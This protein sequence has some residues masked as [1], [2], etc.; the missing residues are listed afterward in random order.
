VVVTEC[1]A[2]AK[3]LVRH[4]VDGLIVD[5]DSPEAL[6][7]A[8]A[9]LMSNETARRAFGARAREVLERFSIESALRKWDA[10]LADVVE[11]PQVMGIFA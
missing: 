2:A 5:S 10:L 7:S 3:Y 1:G 4:G 8:L 6:G 9:S 11:R